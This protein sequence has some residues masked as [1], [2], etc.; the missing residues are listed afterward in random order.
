[1]LS[2]MTKQTREQWEARIREWLE[3]GKSAEEFAANKDYKASSLRWA[4]SRLGSEKVERSAMATAV[5]SRPGETSIAMPRFAPVHVTR[6]VA[7]S[8]EMVVE[9]GGAQIRV[10][11]GADMALL[12][13]VV[14]ALQG[15]ER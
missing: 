7:T 11:R 13:D 15:G 1:M 5:H 8:A 10:T 14:R 2:C 3:S 4:V 6:P 12:R 9:V